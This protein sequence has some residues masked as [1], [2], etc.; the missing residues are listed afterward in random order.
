MTVRHWFSFNNLRPRVA[1]A[2]VAVVEISALTNVPENVSLLRV[3]L[4]VRTPGPRLSCPVAFQFTVSII[5][6]DGTTDAADYD[7][8]IVDVTFSPCDARECVDVPI[9]DDCSLERDET[10]TLLLEPEMRLTDRIIVNGSLTVTIED[11][12][13]TFIEMEH[14][15]YKVFENASQIEVCAVIRPAG[16][17]PSIEFPVRI[18]TR[19]DSAEA[20]GLSAD[21]VSTETNLIF[22]SS[23]NKACIT[24]DILDNIQ[25]EHLEE[26]FYVTL[27]RVAN[28]PGG[29]IL[30]G[31][32]AEVIIVDNDVAEMGFVM[33][34]YTV[35]EEDDQEVEICVEVKSPDTIE[36]PVVHPLEFIVTV[37]GITATEGE[38]YVDPG[39]DEDNPFRYD[40]CAQEHCF[41]IEIKN[42]DEDMIEKFNVT[43]EF[44]SGGV[45]AVTFQQD[46][47]T[48]TIIDEDFSIVLFSMKPYVVDEGV[49]SGKVRVCAS[50][51][52][53]VDF[54]FSVNFTT[55]EEGSTAV[56][57]EDYTAANATLQFR[58]GSRVQCMD[59]PI[60]DDCILEELEFFKLELDN[61]EP[62]DRRS[63]VS[64]DGGG[65]KVKITDEQ[66]IYVSLDGPRIVFEGAGTVNICV[67]IQNDE[68]G[69]PCSR[70]RDFNITFFTAFD[71]ADGED[72]V[73]VDGLQLTFQ[74][75][76]N[77]ACTSVTINDDDMLEQTESFFARIN[78][79]HPHS[80]ITL[81]IPSV[82][83]TIV[84]DD[85][86]TVGLENTTYTVMENELKLYV[87]VVVNAPL[88][89]CPIVFP[90]ELLFVA[91]AATAFQGS[92]YRVRDPTLRFGACAMRQ[93]LTVDIIDN[94]LIED[95][96]TFNLT[97]IHLPRGSTDDITLHPTV[98]TVTIEDE[99]MV[100]V[101]FDRTEYSVQETSGSLT[102]CARVV[103]PGVSCPVTTP[104][105]LTLYVYDRTAVNNSDYVAYRIQTIEF[106][107]CSRSACAPR[108]ITFVNNPYDVEVE[109]V[110]TFDLLLTSNFPRVRPDPFIAEV[111][112]HDDSEKAYIRLEQRTF[113]VT[114][115]V[116]AAVNICAEIYDPTPD[117]SSCPVVFHFDI[118]LSVHGEDFPMIFGPCSR[119][120]CVSIPID[121]DEQLELTK[122][123]TYRLEGAY[124]L[125]RRI[126]IHTAIGTLTVIDDPTDEAVLKLDKVAYIVEEE[127][128]T[129]TVCVE[130]DSPAIDTPI[131]FS[132]SVLL[133]TIDGTAVSTYRGD[134][135]A[136]RRR[137]LYFSVRE[138]RE[139]YNIAITNDD[140]Q[141]DTETFTVT[142][143]RTYSLDPRIRL[144]DNVAVVSIVDADIATVEFERTV[145]IVREKAG[146]VQL[147]VAI[148]SRH[149][150][151][152]VGYDF[153][154]ILG[155]DGEDGG[156]NQEDYVSQDTMGDLI[157]EACHRRQCF[158]VGIV[159]T[160]EVEE[161][162]DF[163]ISLMR[164]DQLDPLI[165]IGSRNKTSVT[166]IDDDTATF[167]LTEAEYRVDEGHT[168][169]ETVC[170]ELLEESGD[171]VVPFSI[172]VIF[173]TRDI[174]ADS[175]EDYE[176]LVAVMVRVPP[177]IS[178]VC[179]NIETVTDE[180]IEGDE[181]LYVSLT[182]GIN[183][184]SRILLN[185]SHSEV[186]I[187]DD[188]AARVT[189]QNSN[190][191][192]SEADRR[193]TICAQVRNPFPVSPDCELDFSFS[194]RLV[195]IAV[196]AG[197]SD[198]GSSATMYFARCT[199][200]A[201][202]TIS[203]R[204]D[205][206]MEKAEEEFI[207]SLQ[208]AN[209]D[210]RLRVSARTSTVQ[211]T[212]DDDIAIWLQYSAYTV[213]ESSGRVQ[214][215]ALINGTS[216]INSTVRLATI[217]DTAGTGTPSDFDSESHS[218]TFKPRISRQCVYFNITD[219]NIVEEREYFNVSLGRTAD[220]DDRVQLRQAS[221]TIFILDD[222]TA[223]FGLTEAEYR[224]EE[225]QTLTETVCV[226]LL[227][228][229]GD[230][231]V[232]FSIKVIF[233]TRD[234]S[235]DSPGDYEALSAVEARIPPCTSLV[236]VNIETVN[237]EL[238]EGDE[239]LY[240]SLTTGFSWD[241]RILLNRSL[242]EVTIE[243][244]D[245]ARVFIQN[246]NYRVSEADRRVTIC[247]QV[248][249]P[250]PVSADCEL[251]F[252]FSVRLVPI[253]V[254]A[255]PSDYGSSA[256][257]YFARCANVACTTITI[258]DDS[259]MEKAE[260]EFIVSLQ[261]ANTDT[262]V[263]I[264]ARTRTVEIADDDDI[265]IWLQYIAY[266]VKESS[267]RVQ[268]CAL[269]NGTSDINSTVR[270]ATISGTAGIG[271]P[272]DF[273]SESHSVTFKP[274]ISRQCVYFNIRDDN[275][276]EEREY[277]NVTL[278]RT[279]DLDDR[280]QLRQTSTTIF[281]LDDDS[282]MLHIVL[283]VML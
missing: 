176:A 23:I 244:D 47:A 278:G 153:S 186:T 98:A 45:T 255:G 3:C 40:A 249:T 8:S 196:T 49:D 261:S 177:C 149:S 282:T 270:L 172:N 4:N 138:T 207:V 240:V 228:K 88:V 71:S 100:I 231:V 223:T 34:A 27:E 129:I 185:H 189:I 159:D 90:F 124:D 260:E 58:A 269:V 193:V 78:I 190:Y 154:L 188:D 277:F 96:E 239:N 116:D 191:R 168:L 110:E 20:T 84:N 279:A 30:T 144:E 6:E 233:N 53:L 167:G 33:L 121:D 281:I 38:D 10:F 69:R 218:V 52:P 266:T 118:N 26:Y 272:S 194:V 224:V 157:I 242:S 254:T 274:R 95:A 113:T 192:V 148:T 145:Y 273:D 29:V 91:T 94:N 106:A 250:F 81:G 257:M 39:Y 140:T 170:V 143:S 182:R 115:G 229:S 134:F 150:Y 74:A 70:D 262:R 205:S 17:K 210:T 133:N 209:T 199:N 119:R 11:D 50:V 85:E 265:A 41:T 92:D 241:S 19:P 183:W 248:R 120:A 267:G 164:N 166:I 160:K 220:L 259:I 35:R 271:T 246:S 201:C 48:V 179:V 132:F 86:A 43:L 60:L 256:T 7:K 67:I 80:H 57:G 161:E 141:E 204:D 162:E 127:N 18:V 181:K 42:N 114:E 169:T 222:D 237:D 200:V 108:R 25:V 16:C 202:A 14:A 131:D 238:V 216:D 206:F 12:D 180:L 9:I 89:D 146:Q 195:P 128:I 142:V 76:Q 184:D 54:D 15:E 61:F 219:D 174:S 55:I 65:S 213:E 136:L 253:A 283:N 104:L 73:A 214:V 32:M 217:S 37:T 221:T 235:A 31:N 171:C 215:C 225:G 175:P 268:V 126:I 247:A 72:F 226:E 51:V 21:Y 59:V 155:A 276:V 36:C 187:E 135:G 163:D 230:C 264:S 156:A 117:R 64:V 275:I 147:C 236:C 62:E 252:S 243:D 178:L 1:A 280:V 258:R 112:I 63:R 77:R 28:T 232:P 125:D 66:T 151:C 93:C 75:F 139:C 197:P 82:E 101:A 2:S 173:N 130:V 24:I 13:N 5:K 165:K 103:S 208:S 97:L 251:D 152:P 46:I 123:Y 263:R 22:S 158:S 87:C 56:V 99:D 203:I 109:N 79:T 68:E 245:A 212:D 102:I 227:E 122:T 234:I 107:R 211:T 111:I 198:Y 105:S 137:S 44:S 83:I